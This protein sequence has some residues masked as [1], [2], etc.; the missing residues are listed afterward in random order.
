MAEEENVETEEGQEPEEEKKGSSK[1]LIVIIAA[2]VLLLG[3]GGFA[4][5]KFFLAGTDTEKLGPDGQVLEETDTNVKIIHELK[6]FIVNL[7]GNQGKRYLK[8]R[9][10]LEVGSD[11]LVQEIKDRK[12]QLRDAVLLLLAG[13]SFADISSPEGKSALRNE[14]IAGINEILKKGPVNT[15]YFT[16]F[17]V[18]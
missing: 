11:D 18:Q 1:K 12:S 4:G 7:L 2:A 3:G 15:L 6:P 16:E 8:A 13:K 5:W 14:L 9:I 10:D 17:V